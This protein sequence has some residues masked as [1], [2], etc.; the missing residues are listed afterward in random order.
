[1]ENQ[2]ICYIFGSSEAV[3]PPF[4]VTRNAEN[5]Y[6][7]AD[8]GYLTAKALGIIPSVILG[9]FDSYPLTDEMR[10]SGAKIIR[11]PVEKDDTDLMLAIKLALGRG[12][13]D[14]EIIG[15]LGGE[16]F[17]HS[18][19]TLQS[20]AYV[21]ENGGTAYAYGRGEDGRVTAATVINGKNDLRLKARANGNVSVF[22]MT[23][24]AEGVTVKGLKYE[25]TGAIM[26]AFF[27]L[28]VS[29]S[30]VGTDAVISVENGSLLIIYDI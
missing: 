27:P 5:L 18:I 12:Y 14:I 26:S 29:N 20:L 23:E 17:D 8:R 2:K 16:R 21:A 13:T 15:C 25:V 1:M 10:E 22:A 3:L 28:G 6:I 19:A 7:A 9:D 30:F 24:K 11:H 4:G